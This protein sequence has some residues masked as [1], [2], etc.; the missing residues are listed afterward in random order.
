MNIPFQLIF[1]SIPS[2]IFIFV[3][4]I[5]KQD[6]NLI[7]KNIGL[8]GTQVK[9]IAIG[10]GMGLV[11]GLF[12]LLLPDILPTDILN[13]PGIAQSV[14]TGWSLSVSSFLLAF[15]R[16]A[17]YIALGEEIFFRGF[18]GKLLYRKL[19]FIA[20]NLIQS[21]VF[22]LP[23]L[24]L[25]TISLRL[26]PILIA[27]FIG[28]WLYGWLCHQ[29]DSILPSWLAHSLGNAFGALVFMG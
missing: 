14:Y 23:H 10:L 1:F 18:L 9:Y 21:I 25:L 20:G 12:S 2:I 28:G 24:L 4:R 29:S 11:P 19:G 13:Q 15:L 8:K 7:I 22:L 16:E 6:W 3:Q 17:I 26:W 27:Q 5:K